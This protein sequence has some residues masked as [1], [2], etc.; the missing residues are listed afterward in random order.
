MCAGSR[1]LG[2]GE[3]EVTLDKVEELLAQSG[4]PFFMGP[5][6]SGVDCAFAPF[7]ERWSH[8]VN[9]PSLSATLATSF[10]VAAAAATGTCAGTDVQNV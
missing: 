6:I 8:Q 1:P 4:G 3:F 9:V 5:T 7:L 2:R 10:V